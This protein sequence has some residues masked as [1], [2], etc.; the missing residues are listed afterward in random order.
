M[1][2]QQ[3]NKALGNV[4]IY[5]LDQ[6]LKGRFEGKLKL[7]DTGCG[8]GRNLH[9]F[10][11]NGYSVFGCDP[12]P[13][14]IKMAQMTY[15][16]VP[17]ENFIV[18]AIEELILPEA[19]FDAIICAAVLHFAKDESH[20]NKMLS[21]LSRLLK[22]DG[23]L[24]IR[25]ATTAGVETKPNQGFSYVLPKENI[26]VVFANAGLQLLEPWKSV[27]VNDQRSMGVFTLSKI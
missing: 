24:F 17:R 7:L 20:F 19:S 3:L 21:N 13:M 15:K 22:K 14:A 1:H 9:Y 6:I 8:E 4:D 27:V 18:S 16:N 5:L 26:D 12:N 25:M 2:Y 23:V 10:A 11:E